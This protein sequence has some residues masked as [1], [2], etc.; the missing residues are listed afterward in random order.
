VIGYT[1]ADRWWT[2]CFERPSAFD[3]AE[4]ASPADDVEAWS[5]EAYDSDGHSWT[6]TFWYD[7][8]EGH[9]HRK[10]K[11]APLPDAS[12]HVPPMAK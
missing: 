7:S 3:A 9:W 11:S 1:L 12:A 2:F 5:V 10:G 6:E 4:D 8:L